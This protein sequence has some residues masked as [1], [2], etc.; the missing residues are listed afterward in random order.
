M[1]TDKEIFKGKSTNE[2]LKF[3]EEENTPIAPVYNAKTAPND[4]QFQH[5]LPIFRGSLFTY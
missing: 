3:S 2:W 1:S 5:R 4:P